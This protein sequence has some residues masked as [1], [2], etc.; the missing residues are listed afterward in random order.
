M[1]VHVAPHRRLGDPYVYCTQHGGEGDGGG[2]RSHADTLD[3]AAA[4]AMCQR[5]FQSYHST[6][7]LSEH[8]LR[9][10]ARYALRWRAPPQGPQPA[11][12]MSLLQ[13]SSAYLP[14]WGA[15]G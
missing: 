8:G 7:E 13:V 5:C 4:L 6:F 1:N 15:E 12:Y 9:A 11:R 14:P 3:S 2:S 10:P